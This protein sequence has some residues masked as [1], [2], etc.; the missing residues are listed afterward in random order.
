MPDD[1]GPANRTATCSCGALTVEAAGEPE[2]VHACCCLNCQKESASAFTYTAFFPDTAVTVVAGEVSSWSQGIGSG[3]GSELRFCPVCGGRVILRLEAIPGILGIGV[4]C[5]ADPT[6]RPP[7]TIYWW[8]RHHHWL[9]APDGI[10][11]EEFDPNKGAAALDLCHSVANDGFGL[12]SAQYVRAN[13]TPLTAASQHI[14]VMEGFG[15][16][17]TA[18]AGSRMLALSSGHA[19]TPGQPGV[20]TNV[21]CG[22]YGTGTAPAGFPQN[23]PG[24]PDGTIIQDDV[25][26]EVVLKAPSNANGFQYEFSF[27][28]HEYPEWVCD[29]YNDQYVALVTPAPAGAINGNIS[30]D[31][32]TNPVSVNIALFEVCEGCALGTDELIG[33]GFDTLGGGVGDS[34]A[35]G[36]LV[37]TA[38]I[39]PGA[40]TTIRF[41][42]WDTTDANF[43]STVIIDNF[44]WIA[45]GGSVSVG[46]VPV[47]E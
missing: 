30:F 34:G 14:G 44:Q 3:R 38:P 2:W 25:G 33:T 26:L 47:P 31:S 9:P 28:S 17:V 42:I 13:G 21:S 19:R 1:A 22:D 27:Y 6:Y 20:C 45:D 46:T 18:R 12:I 41:A 5:F 24:C 10:A 36:W 32:Q 29:S 8:R 37:S 4:G 15:A 39:D 40:E 11:L 16:N 35:T 43:D 23:V 7:A